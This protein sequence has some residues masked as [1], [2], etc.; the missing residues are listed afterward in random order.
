MSADSKVQ[1]TALLRAALKSIAPEL[2]DTPIHL[3]RP[4]QA[5]HGDFATNLALQLAKP[6]RRRPREL[7]ELL[8]AELPRSTLV[9]ATEV[10]GAGFINFTLAAGAKTAAVGTVLERGAEFGRGARNGTSVQLEFVSANPTGPLHVGHGRGAAYGASLAAVLDFAGSDVTREY[11]INDAGRQMDILALSTWLRYLALYGLDIP[12]PPNAYQGDYVVDMARA[13]R[14][15]HQ[16]RFAGFTIEQVLEGAP[17]LPVAERKDDEAK[18]QREDHLDMLIANA[19]RLLGED[20]HFVHG[21]ALNEQL[22][23][24]RDD[25]EEFGVHFDK[26]FSEKSLFD[27]GLV[28]RAVAELEKRGHV[29]LQ[30][31]A[32]WFRSTAFGDEKDRVVQRENGLY[33]Y[34][35]SDIAYH[36]NKYERG[37]D[38]II[39]I[40]GADHHGYIPRVKGAIAALGL[41]PEKLEVALV[42]FAVLYRNGQKASM[43]TRSGEF[44]TLRELRREVGNDACRFFYV[45]RKSDQHLDFDLDLAKSQSNENPVYYVQYAHARVCSVLE[46]WGGEAA[47]LRAAQLDLLGN[48][49][50]LALCARL[51]GFPELIQNAAADHA[52]HQIAFYLKD[53]AA[54]FHSWYNAERMLVDDPALRLARLALATAVRQVLATALAL[55]GVSA[56]QS[57]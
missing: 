48:E 21:F 36:L 27:T 32:K 12:F 25:L 56:P 31:G 17:G 42:Q 11:Y 33:T 15:G 29:Y 40:W 10:A 35:A 54:E 34:F 16:D 26:W 45:L 5:G 20:Y 38:R 52:P 49:R 51:G 2:A 7:A 57:M 9:A 3:E 22:G 50:E 39:D 30:D 13:M 55:L 6:L 53:L 28:D 18:T 1:L 14:E 4:K 47:E 43:S 24:G 44:V 41:P 23:D 8:L 46:Q 19:K 37:Y